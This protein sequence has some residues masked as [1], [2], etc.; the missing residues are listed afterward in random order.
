MGRY[1]TIDAKKDP[2]R[3]KAGLWRLAKV[4]LVGEYQAVPDSE[5][6]KAGQVVDI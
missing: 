2:I 4:L 6:N 3:G 5:A 1:P